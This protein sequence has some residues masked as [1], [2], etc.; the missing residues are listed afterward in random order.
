MQTFSAKILF[1]DIDGTLLNSQHEMPQAVA[2]AIRKVEKQGIPFVF[3]SAR[4]PK[5]IR[6]IQA[7]AGG[8]S[9]VIAYSG[10][11]AQDQEGNCLFEEIVPAKTAV[12]ICGM[13]NAAFPNICV[14]IYGGDHWMVLDP[15]DLWVREEASIT[16]LCAEQGSSWQAIC[17]KIPVHKIF[18]MGMPSEILRLEKAVLDAFPNCDGYRSKDTYLEIV[19]SAASKANA[20]RLFCGRYQY[21]VETSLAFGDYYNDVEMLR[22]AGLGVAMG[23]APEDVKAAADAVTES[24]DLEGV[25]RFLERIGVLSAAD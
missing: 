1:S 8:H 4:M 17:A 24:N 11:L 2:K 6:R 5:S 19:S 25:R 3:V 18:C 21:P 15:E 14:S 20:L 13:A 10:A 12:S 22:A 16:G 23:N 9:P 7:A